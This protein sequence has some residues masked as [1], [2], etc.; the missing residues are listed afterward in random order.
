[1]GLVFYLRDANTQKIDYSKNMKYLNHLFTLFLVFQ[2]GCVS[3]SVHLKLPEAPSV[4]TAVDER[5]DYYRSYGV[6]E[7]RSNTTVYG[8]MWMFSSITNTY[9]TL[10]NGDVI[11]Y[12]EDLLPA[13]SKDTKT[14]QLIAEHKAYEDKSLRWARWSLAALGV[15]TG[16]LFG[17][18]LLPEDERAG[19]IMSLSGLGL[20]MTSIGL[21][22]P[23]TSY[24]NKSLGFRERAFEA[25]DVD[26][27][28]TLHLR[29]R[30][31][32]LNN[33]FEDVSAEAETSEPNE[34]STPIN[35]ASIEAQVE[36]AMTDSKKAE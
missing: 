7:K 15:G 11:E 6:S 29:E 17:G 20:V 23:T 5:V 22:F 33:Q 25:Y 28:K 12:A 27:K 36:A 24:T 35:E 4:E 30:S 2:M 21:M 3:T 16:L 19:D 1:M 10:R 32:I 34:A 8:N 9:L 18:A 26:L 13:L 14:A 31:D